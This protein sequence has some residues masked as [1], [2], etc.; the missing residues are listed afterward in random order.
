MPPSSLVPLLVGGEFVSRELPV[1]VEFPDGVLPIFVPLG[2]ELCELRIGCC[3]LVALLLKG[4]YTVTIKMPKQARASK[5]STDMS[6][7]FCIVYF[8]PF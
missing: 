2:C 5:A 3:R 1:D 8:A 6:E 7:S 4:L